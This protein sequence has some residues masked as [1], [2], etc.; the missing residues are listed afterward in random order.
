MNQ[1][2]INILFYVGTGFAFIAPVS[3]IIHSRENRKKKIKNNIWTPIFLMLVKWMLLPKYWQNAIA[4]NHSPWVDA[5]FM[6][7]F[8]AGIIWLIATI[9]AI[10]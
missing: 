9:A 4:M 8:L 7:K 2:V 6:S 1:S 5:V 3:S 10:M